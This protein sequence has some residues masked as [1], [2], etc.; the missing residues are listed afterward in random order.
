[1]KK[2]FGGKKF[3]L[4]GEFVPNPTQKHEKL[5]NYLLFSRDILAFVLIPIIQ[6]EV[7]TFKDETWNVHRIRAQKNTDLPNGIPNFIYDFPGEY[8]LSECGKVIHLIVK[9]FET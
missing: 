7:N 9:E 6:K 1:M 5:T 8:G 2:N 3:S 4:I